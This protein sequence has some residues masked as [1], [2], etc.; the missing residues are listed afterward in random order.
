MNPTMLYRDIRGRLLSLEGLDDEERQLIRALRERAKQYPDWNAFSNFWMAEV[1]R[2]SATRGLSRQ[3]IQ[4]TVA[5]R[6]GRDLGSRLAVAS[7]L[8]RQ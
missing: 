6:I 1:N 3:E 7:G 5:Y 8:A 2:F 4:E